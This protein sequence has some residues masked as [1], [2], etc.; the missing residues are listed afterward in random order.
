MNKILSAFNIKNVAEITPLG[1]GL[2]NTTFKII[3]DKNYVLQK[4][5]TTVFKN[6]KAIFDNTLLI[7]NYLEKQA[8]DFPFVKP[9]NTIDGNIFHKTEAAEWYRMYPF[10]ENSHTKDIVENADQAYEAAKAF[11][12]FT[13]VLSDI[14]IDKMQPVIPAFHDIVL[15]YNQFLAALKNGNE[16]RIK[17]SKKEIETLINHS[18]IVKLYETILTNKNWKQRPTHHDTKISNV[19]FNV[20]NK[21]TH[22]IDLDTVMPGYFISDVGDMMRTYLSPLSEEEADVKKIIIRKDI[23]QAIEEGYKSAMS[24]QLTTEELNHFSYAGKFMIYM[25]ALRFL[26]DYLLND[27]YYGA[28]YEQHNY[29]RACNQINLLEKLIEFEKE[30]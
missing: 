16:I 12:K 2:I 6:P 18:V 10:I 29:V 11:G 22:V 25:Q 13:A 17:Q 21:A 4:I 1:N 14:E 7:Q 27:I 3:A 15:R 23:Y 24:N 26:T 28:K 8:P 9:C 20:E 19:L 5:N 30:N